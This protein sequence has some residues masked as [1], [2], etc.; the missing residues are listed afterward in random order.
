M[1]K[2]TLYIFLIPL[3]IF[4][5]ILYAGSPGH[6]IDE[7]GNVSTVKMDPFRKEPIPPTTIMCFLSI[8]GICSW[9]FA[10]AGFSYYSEKIKFAVPEDNIPTKNKGI[11][12]KPQNPPIPRSQDIH[13]KNGI[14]WAYSGYN[15]CMTL[16]GDS[17]FVAPAKFV[18]QIGGT[19]LFKGQKKQIS[20]KRLYDE[21][22]ALNLPPDQLKSLYRE[23]VGSCKKIYTII[24]LSDVDM[25]I[26]SIK[27]NYEF[28]ADRYETI[29]DELKER[30]QNIASARRKI[31][32]VSLGTMEQTKEAFNMN[33][34]MRMELADGDKEGRP[35]KTPNNNEFQ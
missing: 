33:K 22:R 23:I 6:T 14:F 27:G 7:N 3:A 35:I 11:M 29:I 1:K 13:K 12:A 8:F 5:A 2:R 25:N 28:G 32:K 18:D 19:I 15:R 10:K 34:L 4:G 31:A 21:L 17:V 26:R 20:N 24:P 16:K 9:S 30:L